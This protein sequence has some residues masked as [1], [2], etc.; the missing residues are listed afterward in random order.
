[1][2]SRGLIKHL[3][4]NIQAGT[5]PEHFQLMSIVPGSMQKDSVL[6]KV[7]LPW[8][9]MDDMET[10]KSKAEVLVHDIFS[11]LKSNISA[12]ENSG[13][14]WIVDELGQRT[15]HR[16]VCREILTEAHVITCAET[17]DSIC[18]AAWP[19]EYWEVVKNKVDMT[20]FK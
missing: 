15:G 8:D 6:L 5:I 7:S 10:S 17:N 20:F 11:F 18:N 1:M 12:F 2:V 16:P 9:P 4:K 3:T 14:D 13:I 19:V